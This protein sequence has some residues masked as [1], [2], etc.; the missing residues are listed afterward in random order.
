[1]APHQR[2]LF[3]GGRER[4]PPSLESTRHREKLARERAPTLGFHWWTGS[5]I[6]TLE[7]QVC[8]FTCGTSAALARHCERTG[9][10]AGV[11]SRAAS[12]ESPVTESGNQSN[13]QQRCPHVGDMRCGCSKYRILGVPANVSA[14]ELR[15][16][17]KALSLEW[18][19]DRTAS[20]DWRAAHQGVTTEAAA[21]EFKKVRRAYE[22][23]RARVEHR[24]PRGCPSAGA[25]S[26]LI[27]ATKANDI[28]RVRSL[29]AEMG[30]DDAELH[31]LDEDGMDALAWACRA[32]AHDLVEL[33]LA[34]GQTGGPAQRGERDGATEEPTSGAAT[35]L[36][37]TALALDAVPALWAAAAGGSAEVVSMVLAA[38]GDRRRVAHAVNAKEPL[39]GHA[40]L[41]AAADRGHSDVVRRL[42]AALADVALT[43][44]RGYSALSVA[45]FKGHTETVRLLLDAR[46]D[47]AHVAEGDTP[48]DLASRRGRVE[49]VRLLLARGAKVTQRGV[50]QAKAKGHDEVLALLTAASL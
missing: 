9:H 45:C 14:V 11:D 41:H 7:C 21:E 19:P 30:S 3:R 5:T 29:L 31:A 42:L 4:A 35:S 50:A 33:L 18:H 1:M 27:A 48:L 16:S 38:D 43:D 22:Q 15:D 10:D 13:A 25:P 49:T 24:G 23:L 2:A 40:S 26:A 34:A 8:G 39:L 36:T 32:R 46:A 20:A 17:F 28:Q 37:T 12:S 6:M 47:V 44:A